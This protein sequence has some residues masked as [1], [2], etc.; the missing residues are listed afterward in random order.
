[1]LGGTGLGPTHRRALELVERFKLET[2]PL[3]RRQKMAYSIHGVL[4]NAEEW[5]NSP[6]NRLVGEEREILPSRLDSY[7][8]QTLLPFYE[9][10]EWTNPEFSHLDVSFGEHLRDKGVSAEAISLINVCI[11]AND[12]EKVSALSIFRDA[13]KWRQV[14]FDDPKNFDQYGDKLYQ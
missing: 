4:M 1:D 6:A 11:N 12:V 5:V 9:L 8:M 7:F 10:A 14:G 3:T 13:A 2:L